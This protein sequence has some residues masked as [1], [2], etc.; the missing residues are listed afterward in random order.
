MS[1]MKV[2]SSIRNYEVI[3]TGSMHFFDSYSDKDVIIVDNNV[4]NKW[5]D[6]FSD[7]SCKIIKIE[8]TEKQKSYKE[9]GRII[10]ALIEFGF[11]KNGKIVA[12]GGGIV[13]DI[14]GFISSVM[15]RGVEW[16]FYPTTLLAQGDSC[17][18][19]K[20]SVNFG[21]YKNQ[22]GN[23]NPPNRIIINS[24]FIDTLPKQDIR[25]GVGEMLHFYL[26][27]GEEDFKYY[28]KEFRAKWGNPFSIEKLVKRCLEIK[29]R[30]IEIDE[31]D[32]K[33]RLVLN[34]GHTFGHAIEA[35]TNH[36]IPHGIAVSM[37]IDIANYI[38]M[39]KGYITQDLYEKL[40]LETTSIWKPE[41]DMKWSG[42]E[43]PQID[44]EKF[45]EILKKDKKNINSNIMCVLTRGVGN[46]FLE[47]IDVDSMFGYLT[48]YLEIKK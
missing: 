28:K 3:F 9:I 34:Y 42:I 46:M 12:V 35:I 6:L 18:G 7:V 43:F 44:V 22:L 31:F 32:K 23:F 14:C 1:K 20:T 5:D 37:G 2:K 38:S 19:G 4:F 17:I 25:S 11:R 30:F 10:Q 15:F 40:N 36:E 24:R 41:Y 13:Q 47:E 21:N 33:E 16:E 45:I 48:S 29:K 27:S 8:A 39:K 26:V